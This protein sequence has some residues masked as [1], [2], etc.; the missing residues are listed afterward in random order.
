[1]NDPIRTSLRCLA[2]LLASALASTAF[3]QTAVSTTA[4]DDQPITLSA[5]EVTSSRDAGYRVENS[6]ATT[7]IAMP[8]D[9]TPLPITV[10]TDQFLKDANLEGFQG[11]LAYVSDVALDPNS[12]DG[13]NPPGL[14]V[15]QS[16]PNLTRFRGQP[17]N[18]TYR[19]GLRQQFGFYTENVDRV[20]VAKGPMAVFIG[21]STLGGEV[22]LVTKK[23]VFHPF[24][25]A[26]FRVASHDSY[27]VN[28]DSTGPLN[29]T[30]AYRVIASY[31]DG[32]TWRDYSHSQ[33]LFVNPQV[34]WRPFAKLSTRLDVEY[35]KA[36]GNLVSQNT[37]STQ[38]YQ[39]A[40]N[41]PPQSL[42][43]LGK[44][45]LGRPFTVAEYR[46]RIG[47]AFGTWRQDVYDT[48]GQWVTLGQGE[49]LTDGYAPDG[50]AYNYF[51]PH[52]GF[53]TEL[54]LVESETTF[55]PTKWLELRLLGRYMHTR[56]YQDY[57]WYGS[58]I[59]PAG[60]TALISGDSFRLKDDALDGKLEGVIKKRVWRINNMLLLGTQLSHDTREQEQGAWDYSTLPSVTGSPNVFGGPAVLTGRNVFTYFDPRTQPFPDTSLAQ[61]WADDVYAAGVPSRAY[62]ETDSQAAYAAGSVNWG[63]LWLT[64]GF[65]RDGNHVVTE[66]RDRNDAI[67][68]TG[69]VLQRSV[70]TWTYTNS[71][72]YGAVLEL[73]HGVNAYASYNY[74]ETYQPGSMVGSAYGNPPVVITRAE[75]DAN[76][77]PNATGTG[78]EAGLKFDLYKDKL[79]ASVGWF[80]LVRGGVLVTDSGRTALDPRNA[81]TEVDP[82]P[83]TADPSVRY[84]VGWLMAVNGDQTS[85][86]ETDIVW[87]PT[88]NY[89]MIL[90]AS[91]LTKNVQTVDRPA[92]NDPTILR[93]YTVL[94]GR[95]LENAPD[96]TFRV[97]QRY[98]FTD[99][100]LKGFSA[101]LGVRYQSSQMPS[102]NDVNWGLVFPAYTV[103]DATFGYATTIHHR[104]TEFQFGVTNLTNRSYFE[105]NRIFGAPR[106]YSFTTRVYF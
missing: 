47:L 75:A 93:T 3:A 85:G 4:A 64:G 20:E 26:D 86:Y 14:G 82:N 6:V 53:E 38:N 61:R 66:S 17:Y 27:Q 79:S 44:K 104:K 39:D 81:G 97:F 12:E 88:P 102:A 2:P 62:N 34:L 58:R 45:T 28:L 1:M 63:R 41:N 46:N 37:A 56:L 105:G 22:N 69:G 50:R 40:F 49:G 30:V 84:K 70:R 18:G 43:D 32:N 96:D 54:S 71:W 57:Y 23:P 106:E 94:N 74:G 42:L 13:N 100:A 91:H 35:R 60:N 31:K 29:P 101:G 24:N 55:A 78:K 90:G 83:N 25:E 8:L 9:K 80:S 95:P 33:V 36:K 68:T 92:S 73:L 19:N 51:G 16:Q 89:S 59:Y 87:T 21:G 65:R 98:K 10:V 15:G 48:T 5:F 72:M 67:T 11:A 77:R 99:G 76:P 103:A 7:G 52:A